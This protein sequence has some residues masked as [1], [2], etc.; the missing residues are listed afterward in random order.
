M[1]SNILIMRKLKLQNDKFYHIYNRG[2]DK[3][4][5]F[6]DEKDYIRFIRSIKEF[7]K[8]TATQG[9]H[10]I[11]HFRK[12]GTESLNFRDSVP[13]V[14]I[15]CYSLLP[16]HYHFILKQ[17]IPGGISEFIKRIASGYTSYFNFKYKRSGVLF[18]G[19]FK[20]IET[21]NEHKLIQI[22]CYING[23]PEIHKISKA[24]NWQ[25]SSYKDYLKLRNGTLCNKNLILKQFQNINEYKN[26][27]SNIIKNNI[28]IK[29]ELKYE[30][31][32]TKK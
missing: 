26:L 10:M 7:N 18:Q 29:N 27:T 20:A 17:N 14:I 12:Q 1:F 22:S 6:V 8:S 11:K 32:H 16:N 21:N 9:L 3:R 28:E 13:L 15:V 25:W 23:N 4:N 31:I 30:Q 2:V 19:K 24:E 5:I